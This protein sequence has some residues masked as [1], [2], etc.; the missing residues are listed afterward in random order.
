[1][2][3]S[4]NET[5]D[6]FVDVDISLDAKRV[7][8]NVLKEIEAEAIAIDNHHE[9]LSRSVFRATCELG[10]HCCH[11]CQCISVELVKKGFKTL[12]ED[13]LRNEVINNLTTEGIS[14]TQE[15]ENNTYTSIVLDEIMWAIAD[16]Y[17]VQI[18]LYNSISLA[19]V[20]VVKH[21]VPT[22][23]ITLASSYV[24]CEYVFY[25]ITPIDYPES[26]KTFRDSEEDDDNA[27]SEEVESLLEEH[28]SKTD[29]LGRDHLPYHHTGPSIIYLRNNFFHS[30]ICLEHI[31]NL[32][33]ICKKSVIR[34]KTCFMVIGD[35]YN[36]N[37]YKK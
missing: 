18:V 16:K 36:P 24:N 2:I 29:K 23:V 9:S 1:M 37:S 34:G 35:D 20:V 6:I 31:N 14:C 28:S 7:K 21:T 26:L 8:A 12:N 3:L 32:F 10:E 5:D 13:I 27:S 22:S 25:N 17:D 15:I 30:N 33:P 4:N 19:P 11:I